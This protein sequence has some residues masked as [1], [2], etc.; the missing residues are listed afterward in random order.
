MNKKIIYNSIFLLCV[1]FLSRNT[2]AQ[3]P[4]EWNK[5][6]GG[7]GADRGHCIKHTSD[8]G[9]IISGYTDTDN[10]GDVS[11]YD[12]GGDIWVV[13]LNTSGELVWQNAYG[14]SATEPWTEA[15]TTV[16]QTADGGYLITGESQSSNGDL[17]ENKGNLDLWVF[18]IDTDGAIEWQKTL[19]GSVHEGAHAVLQEPDGG[20]LL[21]GYTSSADGDVSG[22]KGMTDG[23]LVKL[24]ASGSPLWQKTIGGT[25]T[26]AFT[27]IKHTADGGYIVA[28]YTLSN[29][30][31][32]AGLN[33]D[34]FGGYADYWIV[35]LNSTADVEWQSVIGG[36]GKDEGRCI[37]STTD[38]GYVVAGTTES[39]DGDIT[40]SFGERDWW[41]AK[42]NDTGAIVWQ[43]S[44]GGSERDDIR[45][46]TACADAS[47]FFIVGTTESTDGDA[48]GN[49]GD[50]DLWL[51][52]LD[53]D[54]NVIFNR[55]YGS[56]GNEV[57][58]DAIESSDGGITITGR[59]NGD[60]NGDMLEETQG[61]DLWVFKLEGSTT[62]IREQKHKDFF[63]YPNPANQQIYCSE[64]FQ[65]LAIYSVN[66]QKLAEA[67]NS[68]QIDISCLTP[69]VYSLKAKMADGSIVYSKWVK[70]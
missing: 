7:N 33:P 60:L 49:H 1:M 30:E 6:Y 4:I 19:G 25:W 9:Y 29:D 37:I 8:G 61:E 47:G 50:K 2:S 52:K 12:G 35:K 16:L 68:R 15:Y 63:F 28:G 34:G 46:M 36:T 26:D 43:K 27:S 10:N 65:T 45:T 70:K 57:G 40:E 13:K 51:V 21:A 59:A 39:E 66:G 32:L 62:G 11:G 48:S 18:K 14:G 58:F 64:F 44:M 41:I 22:Q 54:G 67:A 53:Y 17:T 23:W 20:F 5:T 55:C 31:D 56:T 69:G 3:T 24:S 38:G 42:L